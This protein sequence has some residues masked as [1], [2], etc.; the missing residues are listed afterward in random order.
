MEIQT[1]EVYLN[2]FIYLKN[3]Y[4]NLPLKAVASLHYAKKAQSKTDHT[5][6]H[7]KHT[8]RTTKHINE[9]KLSTKTIMS[10]QK[11]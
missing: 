10:L 7:I 11:V 8:S 1:Q 3:L 4:S 5:L 6:K 2:T 9:Q